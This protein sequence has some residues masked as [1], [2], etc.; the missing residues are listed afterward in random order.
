MKPTE[1]ILNPASTIYERPNQKLF[2]KA[3]LYEE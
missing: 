1:N 3:H 2:L